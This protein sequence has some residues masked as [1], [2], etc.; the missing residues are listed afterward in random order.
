MLK[1]AVMLIMT[2]CMLP[3]I[4]LSKA[5]PYAT[6]YEES[7]PKQYSHSVRRISTD[8]SKIYRQVQ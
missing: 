2:T 8:L 1:L 7:I 4:G 3:E 6:A 5:F